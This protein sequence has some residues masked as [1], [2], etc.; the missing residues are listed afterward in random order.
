MGFLLRDIRMR[1]YN[2]ILKTDD[3]LWEGGEPSD[4]TI[5]KKLCELEENG[6]ITTEHKGRD[7]KYFLSPMTAG[8]TW[9]NLR[10]AIDF[11]SE[12]TP[13]GEAGDHIREEGGWSNKFFRFKHHFIAHTLDDE[14][15]YDLLRA[16][17][18]RQSVFLSMENESYTINCVPFKIF[19]SVQTGRRYVGIWEMDDEKN[20][21]S[22]RRLDYIDSVEMMY[23]IDETEFN[24]I[25]NKF[26]QKMKDVWGVSFGI[27]KKPKKPEKVF[28]KLYIDEQNEP[29]VLDRLKREGRRGIIERVRENVFSYSNAVW[30]TNEM[31]PF[32]M[33]F[34]G[35]ILSV[36]CDGPT[37]DRFRN[38]LGKMTSMYGI[39]G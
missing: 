25:K 11:F 13:F 14:V 21:F 6:L 28:M 17:D 30:D 1:V 37:H 4:S 31:M 7:N 2:L 26:D 22:A 9:E 3:F 18:E 35:R 32:I 33:S 16:I 19:V 20:E 12:T 15:L 34:T 27:N 5:R 36:E 38:E 10:R 8:E 23:S 29:F 39:G 24:E